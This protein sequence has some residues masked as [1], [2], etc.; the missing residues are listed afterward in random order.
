MRDI[1]SMTETEGLNLKGIWVSTNSNLCILV[2]SNKETTSLHRSCDHREMT[3]QNFDASP[4]F[5]LN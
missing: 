5:V 2:T 4:S 1:T 3:K